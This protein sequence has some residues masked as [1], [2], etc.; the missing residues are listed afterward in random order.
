MTVFFGFP[1]LVRPA[2]RETVPRETVLGEI[3][4]RETVLGEIVPREIVLG[5]ASPN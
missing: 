1:R 3:V 4:P 2:E 5:E